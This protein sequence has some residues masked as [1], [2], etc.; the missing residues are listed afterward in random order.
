MFRVKIGAD[1]NYA[2]PIMVGLEIL[3]CFCS[4][5]SMSVFDVWAQ[6]PPTIYLV[7]GFIGLAWLLVTIRTIRHAKKKGF[8][9]FLAIIE[10]P[11]AFAWPVWIVAFIIGEGMHRR[12]DFP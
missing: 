12:I 10:A 9:T 11:F 7:P 5:F 6:R 3:L 4:V 1:V 2:T 8:L